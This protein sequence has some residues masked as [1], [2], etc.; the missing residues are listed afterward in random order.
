M[1]C[2]RN[3]CLGWLRTYCVISV[4]QMKGLARSVTTASTAVGKLRSFMSSRITMPPPASVNDKRRLTRACIRH[5]N[6][7]CL[8]ESL[9]NNVRIADDREKTIHSTEP[10][11]L[12]T[13]ARESRLM[14]QRMLGAYNLTLVISGCAHDVRWMQHQ[15]PVQSTIGTD[16]NKAPAGKVIPPPG[17]GVNLGLSTLIPLGGS[18]V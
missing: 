18:R 15:E 3:C 10:A 5:G 16:P 2:V 4:N 1:L 6:P 12:C 9:K 17:M 14:C 13:L 7:P 8:L 11:K